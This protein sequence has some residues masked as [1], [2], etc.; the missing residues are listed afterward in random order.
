MN[1][2]CTATS[3]AFKPLGRPI[4]RDRRRDQRKPMQ[5][6]ATVTVIDGPHAGSS[7]EI[8]TRDLS[9][10]GVSFLLREELAVGHRCSISI[11]NG[12]RTDTHHAEV[13]R[14]RALSNGKYEMAVQFRKA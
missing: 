4:D 2:S 5:N 11:S 9:F 3:S 14:T 13:V 10:S 12:Y 7:H 1:A 8:L 6:K